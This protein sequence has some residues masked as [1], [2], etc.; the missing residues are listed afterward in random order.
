MKLMNLNIKS[1]KRMLFSITL[2]SGL[3]SVAFMQ[4][5]LAQEMNMNTGGLS[6]TEGNV[7]SPGSHLS[8]VP[9]NAAEPN[10]MDGQ[11]GQD[12]ANAPH[13]SQESAGIQG[14]KDDQNGK[15][16]Q[17]GKDGTGFILGI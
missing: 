1:M 5:I 15:G 6:G 8:T 11:D 17:G 14:F 3:V 12:G 16:G 4:S 2:L 7:T 13:E 9:Q 10:V